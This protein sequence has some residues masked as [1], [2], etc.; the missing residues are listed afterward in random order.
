[1]DSAVI[2]ANVS[3]EF[4]A[5]AAAVRNAATC[6]ALGTP[7]CIL[8]RSAITTGR[9]VDT[10]SAAAAAAA[11]DA[12]SLRTYSFHSSVAEPSNGVVSAESKDASAKSPVSTAGCPSE[13]EATA[14]GED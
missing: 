3:A 14:G 7:R 2:D 12:A 4:S 10:V 5:I 1:M 6:A 9:A 8:W 13:E 11:A